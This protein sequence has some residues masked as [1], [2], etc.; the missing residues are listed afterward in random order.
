[1]LSRDGNDFG[2]R[3]MPSDRAGW[4][5]AAGSIGALNSRATTKGIWLCISCC[6]L[7]STLTSARRGAFAPR[8]T[9]ARVCV[10]RAVRAHVSHFRPHRTGASTKCDA[11]ARL[12][13][14]GT[15]SRHALQ[16]LDA[17]FA[18]RYREVMRASLASFWLCGSFASSIVPCFACNASSP[19]GT[20]QPNL[21][22]VL[23][24]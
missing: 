5:N 9:R 7:T 11:D 12:S 17:P 1:M 2:R 23:V 22:Q 13:P 20:W 21:Q 14:I 3:R 19:A 10:G 8:G 4:P 16:F 24:S 18:V 15:A 6:R